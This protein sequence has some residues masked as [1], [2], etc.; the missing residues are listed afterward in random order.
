VAILA[1]ITARLTASAGRFSPRGP[2]GIEELPCFFKVP[3]LAVVSIHNRGDVLAK[4]SASLGVF[5]LPPENESPLSL[6][7]LGLDHVQQFFAR[8]QCAL[9][10][11][12]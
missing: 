6:V 5:L 8:L 2:L 11:F 10:A 7:Y 3:K 1:I 12:R 9:H 4:M